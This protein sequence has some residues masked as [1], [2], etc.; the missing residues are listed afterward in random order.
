MAN[1]R[2]DRALLSFTFVAKA[3]ADESRIRI[4]A[5]LHGHELCVCQIVELLGLA[6]S[7]VSKHLSILRQAYLV[8]AR[9][10]GRWTYYAR[11]GRDAEP[12]ARAALEWIDESVSGDALLRDD[13]RK[14]QTILSTPLETLCRTP[15]EN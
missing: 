8:E 11:V 13:A 10:E 7:T 2:T 5:A 1:G 6:P 15:R 4:L 3:V 14:L 12:A 9:K